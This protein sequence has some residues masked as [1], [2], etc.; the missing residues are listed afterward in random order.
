MIAAPGL[1]DLSPQELEQVQRNREH[2]GLAADVATIADRLDLESAERAMT[3][4]GMPLSDAELAEVGARQQFGIDVEPL[5]EW[6]QDHPHY[7]GA[8][9]RLGR[10]GGLDVFVT[11]DVLADEVDERA[12]ELGLD[13]PIEATVVEHPWDQLQ[14]AMDEAWAAAPDDVHSVGIDTSSNGVTV[15]IRA[16]GDAAAVGARIEESVDVPVT[17]TTAPAPIPQGCNNRQDCW[18]PVLRPG[19][20]LTMGSRVLDVGRRCTMGFHVRVNGTGDEQLLT[21]GHCARA[22]SASFTGYSKAYH[23]SLPGVPGDQG[24]IGPQTATAFVTATHPNYGWDV[25]RFQMPDHRATDRIYRIDPSTMRIVST[26]RYPREN[27]YVCFSPSVSRNVA[28]PSSATISCGRITVED[29]YWR[30]ATSTT[31]CSN[32]RVRGARHD[33]G[34]TTSGDSGAPLWYP[35]PNLQGPAQA[36]PAGL[37]VAG[38]ESETFGSLTR[39]HDALTLLNSHIAL[40]DQ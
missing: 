11:S 26:L 10:V 8:S 12:A 24:R 17:V 29:I 5:L 23:W 6:A 31:T 39:I 40:S 37:H 9:F 1:A 34:S 36:R 20:R 28:S 18:D 38:S 7:A 32:C 13:R 16:D 14:K 30:Y 33:V 27:D 22:T 25:A 19:V 4:Y 2:F 21:A 35:V 3:L 15:E